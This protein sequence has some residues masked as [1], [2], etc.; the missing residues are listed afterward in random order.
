MIWGCGM[1]ESFL[2]ERLLGGDRSLCLPMGFVLWWAVFLGHG[3]ITPMLREAVLGPQCSC[4]LQ[5]LLS[6]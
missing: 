2:E 1:G 6:F 4:L 5:L 3:I